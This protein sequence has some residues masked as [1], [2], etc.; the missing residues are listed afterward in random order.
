MGCSCSLCCL[1]GE[2]SRGAPIGQRQRVH[3]TF[4]DGGA[5]GNPGPGGA[6]STIA[7]GGL[8]TKPLFIKWVG[9][10]SLAVA[11]TTNNVAEYKGLLYGLRIAQAYNLN[12]HHVVGDHR[13]WSYSTEE[14]AS[15]QAIHERYLEPYMM[16]Q[17]P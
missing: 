12:G 1:S 6:G 13:P 3:D 10:V 16:M 5:R 11:A 15:G 9:S 7:V 4:L 14:V 8:V 17:S 2:C